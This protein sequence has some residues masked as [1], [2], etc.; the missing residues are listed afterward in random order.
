MKFNFMELVL[1]QKR[2]LLLMFSCPVLCYSLWPQGLQHTTRGLPAP[3]HLPK[4]AQ[5]HVRCIRDAIQHLILWRP[6]LLLSV[7]PA[8]GTFLVS[9]VFASGDQNIGA[10]ASASVLPVSIQ[11]WFPLR[12]MA[13]FIS[14]M[15]IL[16]CCVFSNPYYEDTEGVNALI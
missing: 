9:W 13:S 3:H 6:L 4:F 12:L 2:I 8:S 10:S 1:L 11:G 5:F 7:F 14:V 16:P 15:I